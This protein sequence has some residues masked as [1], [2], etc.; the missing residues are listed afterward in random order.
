MVPAQRLTVSNLITT[1]G[2]S[3]QAQGS[4]GTRARNVVNVIRGG[5]SSPGSK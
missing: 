5:L 3:W 1:W 2:E 4:L